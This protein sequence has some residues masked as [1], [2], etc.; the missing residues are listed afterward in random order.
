MAMMVRPVNTIPNVR[1]M[2]G[3]G[4]QGDG[5]DISGW[6]DMLAEDEKKVTTEHV[7]RQ[8]FLIHFDLECGPLLTMRRFGAYP[9]SWNVVQKP[10][11]RLK[12]LSSQQR[13]TFE[14]KMDIRAVVG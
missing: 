7:R 6:K 14:V 4:P 10:R 13:S 9:C 8:S 12:N 11:S 2:I 5:R 3:P 1:L